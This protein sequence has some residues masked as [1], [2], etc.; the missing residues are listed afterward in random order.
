MNYDF[1]SFELPDDYFEKLEQ[2]ENNS[3]HYSIVQGQLYEAL[4]SDTR[5][6]GKDAAQVSRLLNNGEVQEA[7]EFTEEVLEV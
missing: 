2:E 3:P 7:K 5:V 1:D 4:R 6:S